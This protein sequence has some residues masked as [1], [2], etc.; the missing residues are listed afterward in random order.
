M[1]GAPDYR[2]FYAGLYVRTH[3]TEYVPPHYIEDE[4]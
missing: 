1:R 2:E 4:S 3:Q